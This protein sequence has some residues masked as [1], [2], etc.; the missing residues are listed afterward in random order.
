MSTQI[1]IEDDTLRVKVDHPRMDGENL[2]LS[3]LRDGDWFDRS[4][5]RLEIDFEHVEYLNSLGITELVTIHRTLRDRGNRA[6]IRFIHV[7]RK[8]NAILELVE[9]QKIADIQLKA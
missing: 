5:L 8:V 7:D 6:R 1:Q 2:I 4:F 3:A 9:L